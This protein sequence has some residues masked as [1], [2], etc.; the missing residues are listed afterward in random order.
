MN[1]FFQPVPQTGRQPITLT[2]DYE[3][4]LLSRRMAGD[5]TDPFVTDPNE[6]VHILGKLALRRGDDDPNDSF[7]LG[8]LCERLSLSEE[9]LRVSYVAKTLMAYRRAAQQADNSADKQLADRAVHDYLRWVIEISQQA[10]TPR[11]LAVALWAIAEI[12]A[13]RLPDELRDVTLRLVEL[14][15]L[16]L[17]KADYE[18]HPTQETVD[19]QSVTWFLPEFERSSREARGLEDTQPDLVDT[20]AGFDP[21]PR[22]IKVINK[23][24]ASLTSPGGSLPGM[25]KENGSPSSPVLIQPS[26][27]EDTGDFR[28]GEVLGNRYEVRNIVRGGMGII[29]LCYD[30]ETRSPV[31][32]KT[33]QGRF[34]ENERAM[35]RFIQEARTWIRLEKHNHIVQAK[36]VKD[37]GNERVRE[38]PHIVLEYIAGPEGLGPDLKSWIDHRRLDL[39][40]SLQIALGI[41]L[42][43]EHAVQQ[44]PGLVHRDLKPANILVRHDGIAKVTDFGLA[45]SLDSAQESPDAAQVDK[46][47]PNRLT[48]VGA[49]V[50]TAPYMSPEQCRGEAL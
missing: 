21:E 31:A 19:A 48:R 33:F 39:E 26:E 3:K 37:I 41:C 36:L 25:L 35:A 34:L 45:Y 15:K 8:D 28:R 13:D 38:R 49:I 7:A 22:K 47:L 50:G 44:V 2:P 12:P 27:D 32:I 29:Y 42:G 24:D 18:S 1:K 5:R 9:H 40:H 46:A 14:Y 20:D 30:L 16:R 6:A 43:M 10:A 23:Q 11:N 4:R 17:T